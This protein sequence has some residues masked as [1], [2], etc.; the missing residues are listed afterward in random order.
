MTSLTLTRTN[1]PKRHKPLWFRLIRLSIIMIFV[2]FVIV[3]SYNVYQTG[4][5]RDRMDRR[6]QMLDQL[7]DTLD[8]QYRFGYLDSNTVYLHVE[9]MN[10]PYVADTLMMFDVDESVPKKWEADAWTRRIDKQ[11]KMNILWND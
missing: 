5:W 11:W 6:S 1:P 2:S 3:I 9:I 7:S 8:V 10:R 4:R